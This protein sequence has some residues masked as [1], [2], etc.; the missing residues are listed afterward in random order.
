MCS[1]INLISTSS[2]GYYVFQTK[3]RKLEGVGEEPPSDRSLTVSI[4]FHLPESEL[5]VRR[6]FRKQDS[7]QVCHLVYML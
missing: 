1:I 5:P 3:K 4:R 6:R 2:C 7:L